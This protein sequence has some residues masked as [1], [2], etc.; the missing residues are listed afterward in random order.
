MSGSKSSFEKKLRQWGLIKYDM[1]RLKWS[2]VGR[3]IE[4]RRRAGKSS[5]VYIRGQLVSQ[6]K[7]RKEMSRHVPL[8]IRSQFAMDL[9]MHPL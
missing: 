9:S 3:I 8:T 6:D 1:G 4:R 5:D 2:A 7:V